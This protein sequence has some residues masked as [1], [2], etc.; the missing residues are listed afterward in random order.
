[1]VFVACLAA[2]RSSVRER[3][4]AGRNYACAITAAN[5]TPSTHQQRA[6]ATSHNTPPPP[7]THP[8]SYDIPGADI[9][10]AKAKTP[11]TRVC[12]PPGGYKGKIGCAAQT[13]GEGACVGHAEGR[14]PCLFSSSALTQQAPPTPPPPKSSPPATTPS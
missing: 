6:S 9:P 10:D 4:E 12:T 2:G 7:H 14:E 5:K 3:Q 8:R 11:Y 1:M 13:G